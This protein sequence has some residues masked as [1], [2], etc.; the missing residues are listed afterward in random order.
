MSDEAGAG[1]QFAASDV[2][3]VAPNDRVVM[4]VEINE[5]TGILTVQRPSGLTWEVNASKCRIAS[6]DDL[7]DWQVAVKLQE[8]R[9]KPVAG[10]PECGEINLRIQRSVAR[11]MSA[12]EEKRDLVAHL[13]KAH[14]QRSAAGPSPV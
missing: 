14:T 13:E 8:G 11:Q 6:T 4:I 1:K 10:C 7:R 2:V 12:T 3:V 5:S 9:R